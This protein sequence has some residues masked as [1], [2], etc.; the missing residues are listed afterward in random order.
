LKPLAWGYSE[1]V[2]AALKGKGLAKSTRGVCFPYSARRVS[3]LSSACEKS[4]RSK[5]KTQTLTEDCSVHKAGAA[6][7]V[8]EVKLSPKPTILSFH[9]IR[10]CSASLVQPMPLTESCM[11]PQGR[12]QG[13]RAARLARVRGISRCFF[14]C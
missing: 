6:L 9:P 3:F 2:R 14:T 8:R 11:P 10:L 5:T 7:V 1:H 13:G 4:N 12:S